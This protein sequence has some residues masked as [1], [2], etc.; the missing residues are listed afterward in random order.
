MSEN[1]WIIWI[2]WTNWMNEVIKKR[3][4]LL[5]LNINYKLIL[6]EVDVV[7]ICWHICSSLER[8]SHTQNTKACFAIILLLIKSIKKIKSWKKNTLLS[9]QRLLVV[10]YKHKLNKVENLWK[11]LRKSVFLLNFSPIWW[12]S[13]CCCIW[14][15]HDDDPVY[16]H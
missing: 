1:N 5:I 2:I 6:I 12:F 9:N 8:I 3:K 7:V 16:F 13:F 10:A 11:I 14:L 15:E 4:F